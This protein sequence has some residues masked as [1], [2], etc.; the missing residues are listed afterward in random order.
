MYSTAGD[1]I[2]FWTALFSG[3]IVKENT[4]KLMLGEVKEGSQY[5]LGIELNKIFETF[6][7]GHNGSTPYFKADYRYYPKDSFHVVFLAN[8][9]AFNS[10]Q[11]AK[12]IYAVLKGYNIEHPVLPIG[13]YLTSVFD[14][15][16]IGALKSGF[17]QLVANK[18]HKIENPAILNTYGYDLLAAKRID[19][20]ITIFCINVDLFPKTPNVYDSLGEA[21]LLQGNKEKAKL[22]YQKVLELDPENVNAKK[23]LKDLQN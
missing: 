3:K 7:Y 23:M 1:M 22:N 21:Y 2:S 15:K 20:A 12:N 10:R 16:G 13:N 18:N 11:L 9:S 5:G 8:T 6:A 14:T 17:N 19:E 4:L